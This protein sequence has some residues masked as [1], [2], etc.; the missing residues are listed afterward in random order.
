MYFKT[1]SQASG[2]TTYLMPFRTDM[3]I[4]TIACIVCCACAMSLPYYFSNWLNTNSKEEQKF[5]IGN[6]LIVTL[7]AFFQQG[8]CVCVCVNNTYF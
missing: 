2:W 8:V 1:P 6:T 7:G 4:V 5:S 3:L